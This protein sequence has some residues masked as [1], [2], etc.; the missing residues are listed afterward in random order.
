MRRNGR[1]APKAVAHVGRGIET[2]SRGQGER[3]LWVKA[4]I[5]GSAAKGETLIGKQSPDIA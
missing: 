4:D 2:R 1:D 5:A 3:Q